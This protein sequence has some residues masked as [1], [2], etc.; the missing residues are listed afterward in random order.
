[1]PDRGVFV[2]SK[3]I[4]QLDWRSQFLKDTFEEKE[5]WKLAK[6]NILTDIFLRFEPPGNLHCKKIEF[7]IKDFFS[8]RSQICRKLWLW[9]HLLKKTLME[10][11]IF[12]AVL[13]KWLELRL[14]V[15]RRQPCSE[16]ILFSLYTKFEFAPMS[17]R[18]IFNIQ[19]T[20]AFWKIFYQFWEPKP[21]NVFFNSITA[22]I[23]SKTCFSLNLRNVCR[24]AS[25]DNVCFKMSITEAVLL[26]DHFLQLCSFS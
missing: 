2:P 9:S 4:C 18:C 20:N 16:S 19:A 17:N 1:M 21:K 24:L 23:L 3:N 10:N 12:C 22:P 25:H 6:E 14:Q 5:F 7:S 26:N 8:K 11:F 15:F 13:T